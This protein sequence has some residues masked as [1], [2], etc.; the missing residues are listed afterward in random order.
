MFS[1][2]FFRA[3]SMLMGG[4]SLF[5][6]TTQDRTPPGNAELFG[7]KIGSAPLYTH[8]IHMTSH[9]STSFSSD[10][11]NIVGRKSPFHHVKNYLWPFMKSTES[12]RDQP[13][14]TCFS[15]EWRDPNEF[16]RTMMIVIHKLNTG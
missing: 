16:L 10:M 1:Q 4:E 12:S 13:W 11:S 5:M 2:N 6:L 8:C 7:T 9:H 15:T 14:R 3:A